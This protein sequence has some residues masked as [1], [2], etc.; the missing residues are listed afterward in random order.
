MTN[1]YSD[2]TYLLNCCEK[3]YAKCPGQGSWLV[4]VNSEDN[5]YRQYCV[6]WNIMGKNK[7]EG[8]Q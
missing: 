4:T 6:R 8:S 2:S 5:L 3:K 7:T 1:E